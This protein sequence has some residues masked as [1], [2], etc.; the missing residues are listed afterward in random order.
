MAAAP[1]KTA[2]RAL[3]CHRSGMLGLPRSGTDWRK[4][5][6]NSIAHAPLGVNPMAVGRHH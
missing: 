3:G 2:A 1:A 5:A 6:K 4:K